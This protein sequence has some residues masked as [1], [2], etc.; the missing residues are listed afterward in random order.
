MMRWL[1]TTSIRQPV[2]ILALACSLLVVGYATLDYG[3]AGIE[4][5][6]DNRLRG[7]AR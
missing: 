6:C 5:V 7:T 4:A 2:L 1:I 3:T